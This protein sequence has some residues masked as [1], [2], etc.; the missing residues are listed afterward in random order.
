MASADSSAV[1]AER[2][3][4]EPSPL[5]ERWKEESP[6]RKKGPPSQDVAS[7][8]PRGWTGIAWMCSLAIL[9]WVSCTPGKWASAG[10]RRVP[11]SAREPGPVGKTPSDLRMMGHRGSGLRGEDVY[12]GF[13]ETW[14]WTTQR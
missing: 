6:G 9:G 1:A 4:R 8:S 13:S 3:S 11:E 10:G 7:L 2:R 5:Q 14:H 12:H